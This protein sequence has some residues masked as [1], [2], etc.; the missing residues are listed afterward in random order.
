MYSR[1]GCLGVILLCVCSNLAQELI[2]EEPNG[3]IDFTNAEVDE[4][5]H[6]CVVKT[7]MI[8][9]IEK[10]QVKECWTQNVTQCHDS[11]VT[12]FL[13]MQERQCEDNYWKACKIT[14]KDKAYNTTLTSCMTPLVRE[15]SPVSGVEPKTVC[16]TWFESVCN[17]TY[18]LR[19]DPKS[20]HENF[21]PVTW[22]DKIPQEICA[23]DHCKMVS[24]QEECHNKIIESTIKQ[25]KEICDLRPS[26]QCKLVTNL[27]PH[28]TSH[29]VCREIPKEV[30]H[31]KDDFPKVVMKPQLLK[32]CTRP[33]GRI[34]KYRQILPGSKNINSPFPETALQQSGPNFSSQ[35]TPLPDNHNGIESNIRQINQPSFE[36]SPPSTSY[37]FSAPSGYGIPSG[38]PLS[39]YTSSF[40][41]LNRK[42]SPELIPLGKGG[43]HRS[44]RFLLRSELPESKQLINIVLKKPPPHIQRKTFLPING[45]QTE[46]ITN[47]RSI[48]KVNSEQ[49]NSQ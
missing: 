27:V 42:R 30:C 11:F 19:I 18:N 45:N 22:C 39:D 13:P 31:V 49:E 28:L 41:N 38:A 17:T 46:S 2:E 48:E 34:N 33:N 26:K 25:P 14:F 16:K 10:Q 9:T 5:G 23:P 12:E 3:P 7:K 21:D 43:H 29:K 1:K 44:E 40:D 36:Q 4:N 37:G 35:S 15:C 24:G 47:I 6:L 20:G 8:E 32:W